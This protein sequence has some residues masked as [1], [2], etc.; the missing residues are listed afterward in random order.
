MIPGGARMVS[1]NAVE[2]DLLLALSVTWTLNESLVTV[3]VGVPLIKPV[4]ESDK[5]AGSA[6]LVTVHVV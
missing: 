3:V 6:P 4:L 5:P 2:G 1:K